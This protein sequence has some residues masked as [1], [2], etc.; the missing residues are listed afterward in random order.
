MIEKVA[1]P[2]ELKYIRGRL[3]RLC[4]FYPNLIP[5]EEIQKLGIEIDKSLEASN[6]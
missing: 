1:T 3:A 5:K 2:L 6:K 4:E